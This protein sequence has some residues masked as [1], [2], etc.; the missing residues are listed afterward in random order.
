VER[1]VPHGPALERAALMVGHAGHGSV[2][3][4]LWHG[5][6]MV[7]VPWGRDQGGRGAP[8]E[9]LGV[10]VIVLRGELTAERLAAAAR[11][12]MGT[13][14]FAEQA[15]AVSARLR[16]QVRCRRPAPCSLPMRLRL[17][18]CSDVSIASR[19]ASISLATTKDA[20]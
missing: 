7:L 6:P 13:R 15:A 18:R 4:A 8:S 14:T 3:R 16:V 1:H 20:S 9:R 12:V 2:M 10:A 19:P 5:V 11:H 17:R